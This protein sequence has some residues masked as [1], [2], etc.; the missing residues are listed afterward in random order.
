MRGAAM[1]LAM[2]GLVLLI[3]ACSPA[4]EAAKSGGDTTHRT[5]SG[6]DTPSPPRAEPPAPRTDVTPPRAEAP[7]P[8]T[9]ARAPRTEAPARPAE[10]P[11]PR[12]EA[13]ARGADAPPPGAEVPRPQENPAPAPAATPPPAAAPPKAPPLDLAA[14]EKRLRDTSAI[15]TFT[16]LSLKNQVDDLLGQFGAFH[17]GQS[18][19]KLTTLREGFDLLLLKVLSLLQDKD[20]TLARD[21]GASREA[22]WNL[23]ADPAKF[24]NL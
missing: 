8:R 15:G 7:A 2:S 9:G 18:Q 20:P 3:Q 13:P 19:V 14:L 23:L 22:L 21:I 17:G 10:A 4:D 1:T 16:K 12:T 24:A 5:E 6:S 11:R